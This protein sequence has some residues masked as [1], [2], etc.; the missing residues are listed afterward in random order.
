MGSEIKTFSNTDTTDSSNSYSN[1]E[2]RGK[3]EEKLES[4]YQGQYGEYKYFAGQ[5]FVFKDKNIANKT[6]IVQYEEAKTH[7]DRPYLKLPTGKAYVGYSLEQLKEVIQNWR[8]EWLWYFETFGDIPGVIIPTEEYSTCKDPL[9]TEN[10]TVLVS[11]QW[12]DRIQGDILNMKEDKLY[13]YIND[14]PEFKSTLTVLIKRL[15]GLS[16]NDI[17]PDYLG[18]DNFAIYLDDQIPKIAIIDP[19]IVWIG[20]ACSEKIKR[21]L[22]KAVERFKNI[23]QNS[24][25]VSS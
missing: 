21:S 16:E 2:D 20:K 19:H 11:T 22:E 13:K 10:N 4:V 6:L 3:I 23:L 9:G 7:A 24:D 17:Y 18:E 1:G 14:F 5:V 15:L 8:N 25:D 12:I